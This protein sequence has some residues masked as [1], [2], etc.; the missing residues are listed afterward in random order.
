MNFNREPLQEWTMFS[1][2]PPK[3]PEKRNLKGRIRFGLNENDAAWC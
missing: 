3:G 2:C 1:A